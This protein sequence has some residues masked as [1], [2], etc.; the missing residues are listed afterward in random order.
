MPQALNDIAHVIQLAIAPVFL[1]TAI[2]TVLNVLAGRLTRAVDR[3]RVLVAALPRL[4]VDAAELARAEIA[5]EV[6]RIRLVYIAIS[7]AVLSALLVCLLI[8]LAFI[9]AFI[10]LDLAKVVAAL[11]VLAM[12]ALIASLTVFMREIFLSVN[13]PRA[14]VI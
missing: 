4:D 3:R 12:A 9:D 6:R 1:L 13:S 2:G 14:P 10:A 7:M 11:F 5:F 8:Q